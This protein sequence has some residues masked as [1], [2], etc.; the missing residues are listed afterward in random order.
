MEKLVQFKINEGVAS[1]KKYFS[2]ATETGS[3]SEV[4]KIG[5]GFK[6]CLS[7]DLTNLLIREILE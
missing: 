1:L 6:P 7:I 2:D 3:L 5:I 4:T